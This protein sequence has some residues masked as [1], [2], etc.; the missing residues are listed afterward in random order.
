[1]ES[2]NLTPPADG[3]E[4]IERRTCRDCGAGFVLTKRDQWFF[5][6]L[7]G[8]TLPKRC[9]HCR[10]A[11]RQARQ[12]RAAEVLAYGPGVPSTEERISE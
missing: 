7:N 1:M 3:A 11:A 4:V 12:M 6:E 2:E 8:Y 10:R 5:V 9:L